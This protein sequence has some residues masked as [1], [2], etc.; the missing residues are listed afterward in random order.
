MKALPVLALFIVISVVA[1]M[2]YYSSNNIFST[3][4]EIISTEDIPSNQ[5]DPSVTTAKKYIIGYNNGNFTDVYSI[6][7][8]VFDGDSSAESF[9]TRFLAE[10][11]NMLVNMSALEI[12]NC[13]GSMFIVLSVDS[14][15]PIGNGFLVERG[16]VLLY[17]LG[18]NENNLHKVGEWFINRY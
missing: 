9:K 6:K 10:T 8:I 14:G 13:T 16:N 18:S 15:I 17:A 2:A 3:K 12:G 7:R 11:S 1:F 4:I 5:I